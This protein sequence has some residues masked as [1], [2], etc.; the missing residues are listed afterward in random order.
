MTVNQLYRHGK[1]PILRKP[2]VCE[3]GTKVECNYDVDC[4]QPKKCCSDGCQRR[5]VNAAGGPIPTGGGGGTKSTGQGT[6][7]P[8]K[9]P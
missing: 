8:G 1:C 7:R 3:T 6:S 9:Q 2:D 5:C 4:T